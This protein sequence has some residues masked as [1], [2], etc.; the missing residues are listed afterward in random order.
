MPA[1][2]SESKLGVCDVSNAQQCLGRL[3]GGLGDGAVAGWSWGSGAVIRDVDRAAA[4]GGGWR[5]AVGWVPHWLGSRW[6][7]ILW[8]ARGN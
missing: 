2:V 7:V 4:G 6:A 3:H 5:R 1:E 8:E